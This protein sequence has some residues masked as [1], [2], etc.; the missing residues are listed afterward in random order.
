MSEITEYLAGYVTAEVRAP[1]PEQFLGLCAANDIDFWDVHKLD[2]FTIRLNMRE[3]GFERAKKLP[4]SFEVRAAQKRGFP[5]FLRKFKKRYALLATLAL[6]LLGIFTMSRF[7][8][9]IEVSGNE[10][11]GTGE[12]ITALREMGVK[13]GCL[14]SGVKSYN[15]RNRILVEIPELI[16]LTVNVHGSRAEVIVRERIEKPEITP[17]DAP[18]DV[19][20]GK[21]GIIMEMRVLAGTPKVSVG[22]TAARGDMLVSGTLTNTLLEE[23]FVRAIAEVKARTWYT[24]KAVIPMTVTEKVYTGAEKTRRSLIFGETRIN[25]YFDS[26][27]SFA[28]CDKIITVKQGDLFGLMVLPVTLVTERESEFRP[29][30]RR[31]KEAEAKKLL[32]D[33][34]AA[35]LMKLIDGK[36]NK[37][38]IEYKEEDGLMTAVLRAECLED[39]AVARAISP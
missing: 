27:N 8:W 29:A 1:Y 38:D 34:L 36:I 13:V 7:I 23:R 37:I 25:L 18:A 30:P 16:W 11:V 20:A 33:G 39:I 12:I 32:R 14:A 26:S 3:H 24:L 21:G 31:L 6:C 9:H 15:I 4:G 28:S 35:E 22:Q 10:N 2:E 17:I 5:F 19:I